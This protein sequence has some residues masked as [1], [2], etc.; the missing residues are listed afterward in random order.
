LKIKVKRHKGIDGHPTFT[1]SL[2]LKCGECGCHFTSQVQVGINNPIIPCP[3]C[4]SR[5]LLKLNWHLRKD[6]L[7]DGDIVEVIIL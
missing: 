6:K 1:I 5:N 3:F 4:Y 2:P 7:A